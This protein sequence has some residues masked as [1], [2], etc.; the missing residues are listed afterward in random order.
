MSSAVEQ[1]TTDT[2]DQSSGPCLE[3]GG[4]EEGRGEHGKRQRLTD[5]EV[6][7]GGGGSGE[8]MRGGT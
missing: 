8:G 4:E 5:D 1:M 2:V 6:S 3:G 7:V